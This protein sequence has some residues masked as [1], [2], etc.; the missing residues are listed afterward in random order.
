MQPIGQAEFGGRL[1]DFLRS[2][3]VVQLPIQFVVGHLKRQ[4]FIA[5]LLHF[6]QQVLC[7][8]NV[9]DIQGEKGGHGQD[10]DHE[11]GR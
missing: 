8:E 5:Q 1:E 4:L 10:D 9:P 7:G 6:G 11:P 3:G 2:G